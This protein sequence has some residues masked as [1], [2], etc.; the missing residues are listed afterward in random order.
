[1]SLVFIEPAKLSDLA[2]IMEIINSSKKFLKDSGS[3][4][5]Q[6]GYP[7]EAV[8]KQDITNEDAW[9][10][11][12]DGQT[13]GYAAIIIGEEPTYAEISHGSWENNNDPYATIHRLAISSKYRGQNLSGLMMSNLISAMRVKGIE[14]Y[15]IDTAPVNKIVQRIAEKNG[16]VYRG[17]I[18][19][20]NESVDPE[21]VAYELNLRKY[22]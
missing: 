14:N 8:I 20:D 1:M 12:V 18:E 4:Q 16:F 5:W 6:N 7:D 19:V 10:L 21:R 2:D 17:M 22:E 9:I 11:K 15:R 3:N 13:A